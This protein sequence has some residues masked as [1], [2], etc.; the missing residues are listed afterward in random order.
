M[1]T[2]VQAHQAEIL[3]SVRWRPKA[4]VEGVRVDED[5]PGTETAHGSAVV[6]IEG[7][8]VEADEVTIKWLSESEENLLVH[9]RKVKLFRQRRA[10]P[11]ETT[12]LAMLTMANTHVS[13][14]Q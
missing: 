7:L 10:Q 13:F 2:L 11:Y 6:T 14:F 3:L 9:A 1:E 12:D 8:R 5:P 4:K